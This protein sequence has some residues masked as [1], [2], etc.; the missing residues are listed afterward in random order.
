MNGWLD[1]QNQ[2]PQ[3]STGGHTRRDEGD[4]DEDG[5]GIRGQES[6]SRLSEWA[7]PNTGRGQEYAGGGL[8][9]ARC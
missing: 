4:E 7:D 2:H 3:N 1:C 9:S 8:P 6:L 5:G